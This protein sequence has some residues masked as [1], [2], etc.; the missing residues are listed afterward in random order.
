MLAPHIVRDV[1]RVHAWLQVSRASLLPSLHTCSHGG[2]ASS[3]F[4]TQ[5]RGLVLTSLSAVPDQQQQEQQ[6]RAAAQACSGGD[7]H[8]GQGVAR[9]L[10]IAPLRSFFT[11]S[12]S[13]MGIS[14]P[15]GAA[16]QQPAVPV[17][18]AAGAAGAVSTGSGADADGASAAAARPT[19][20]KGGQAAA[21]N[22][23]AASSSASGVSAMEASLEQGG[24]TDT[25]ILSR[26]AGYLWPQ[27]KERVLGW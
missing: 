10:P 24:M 9:H 15:H 5:T 8:A 1:S 25:R 2:R 19:G 22:G 14:A 27:G 18:A 6:Q 11:S 21:K 13:R 7:M 12:A 4:S 23:S 16:G 3:M 17:P 26:L 20:G